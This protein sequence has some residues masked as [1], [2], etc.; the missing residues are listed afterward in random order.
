MRVFLNP[1]QE[2]FA[3]KIAEGLSNSEAARVAG[4]S[5]RSARCLGSQLIKRQKIRERIQELRQERETDAITREAVLAELSNARAD[6][7]PLT[8]RDDGGQALGLFVPFSV[9]A[10]AMRPGVP[11]FFGARTRRDRTPVKFSF[12][13]NENGF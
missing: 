1:K 12:P 5:A 10:T 6:L 4:Y 7:H 13:Q 2:L 9:L 11:I 8:I 3:Q